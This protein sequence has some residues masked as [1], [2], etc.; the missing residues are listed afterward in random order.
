MNDNTRRGEQWRLHLSAYLTPRL[1]GVPEAW[2]QANLTVTTRQWPEFS[3]F[4]REHPEADDRPFREN[5]DD[6]WITGMCA[7]VGVA[8]PA[9]RAA[10]LAL[11]RETTLYVTHRCQAAYPGAAAAVRQ[12]R[13][14]GY[15]LHTASGEHSHELIGYLTAMGI[16]DC[17]GTLFGPDLIATGKSGPAYYRRILEAVKL[18]PTEA[19]FVDDTERVLNWAA[20][21]GAATVLCHPEP[22]GSPRHRHVR[23]LAELPGALGIG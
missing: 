23:V 6:D 5:M 3:R 10:R 9:T 12:L 17:F 2:Q 19:L 21:L 15:V 22:P 1:G 14:A 18:D 7:E 11:T 4:Y 20:D 16:A 8:P 13:A